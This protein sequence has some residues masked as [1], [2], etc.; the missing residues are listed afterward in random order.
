[1]GRTVT[2]EVPIFTPLKL[3]G[4]MMEPKNEALVQMIFLFKVVVAQVQN[5]N[6]TG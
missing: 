4:C 2:L 3:Y 5:L 1:M 6:F